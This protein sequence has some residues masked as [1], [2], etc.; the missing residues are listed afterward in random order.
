[1]IHDIFMKDWPCCTKFLERVGEMLGV[2]NRSVN[3]GLV[4]ELT[5]VW[6]YGDSN[7]S[8]VRFRLILV[9]WAGGN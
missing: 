2:L 9:L 6:R 8:S 4:L 5:L 3:D 1:M 7:S